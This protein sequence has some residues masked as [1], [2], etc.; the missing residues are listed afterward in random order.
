MIILSIILVPIFVLVIITIF[1]HP[2]VA[3]MLVIVAIPMILAGIVPLI[4]Y[5]TIPK[6][7]EKKIFKVIAASCL[8]LLGPPQIIS[9]LSQSRIAKLIESDH[10]DLSLPLKFNSVAIRRFHTFKDDATPCDE[11]CIHLLLSG[12]AER[13]IIVKEFDITSP[14]AI[15]DTGTA[16]HLET[17]N[18][19]PVVKFYRGSQTLR[20]SRDTRYY[21]D[22]M[23]HEISNGRCLIQTS[24]NLSSA[25]LVIS[26]GSLRGVQSEAD[27][28]LRRVQNE[29]EVKLPLFSKSAGRIT[30]HKRADQIFVELLRW[31][32]LNY[33]ASLFFFPLP[34]MILGEREIS[35]GYESFKP[36][37]G[38][39]YSHNFRYLS[40]EQ[41]TEFLTDRM[42]INF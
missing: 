41:W 30:V 25:D 17:R 10:N 19:C 2:F 26:T 27:G 33:H 11:I 9:L 28:S 20:I 18:I 6:N 40:E 38:R 1:V 35:I 3:I 8:V 42:G 13:V 36:T 23:K 32:G 4:F 37:W 15:Q 16:F 21:N 7:S 29:A 24:T 34:N 12:I 22:K 14:P 5:K 39:S 31:T